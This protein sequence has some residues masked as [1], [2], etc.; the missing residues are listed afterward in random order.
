MHANWWPDSWG[1]VEP[2]SWMKP[3]AE[4]LAGA[5]RAYLEAAANANP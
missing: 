2:G 5:F 4:T 1:D 3:P